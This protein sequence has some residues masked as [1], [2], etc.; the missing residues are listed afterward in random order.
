VDSFWG[1]G[2]EEA[3]RKNELYGE[4]WSAGR[5]GGGGGIRGWWSTARGAGRLYTVAWCSGRG[6]IGWREARVGC[7]WWLSGG[8]NGGAVGGERRRRKK[9]CSTVGVG[10]LYSRQRRWTKGG[11]VVKPRAAISSSSHGGNRVGAVWAPT[12]GPCC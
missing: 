8:G 6:R 2:K 9:G 10:A 1:G 5:N 11:M 7:L 3:H 12:F 4:V